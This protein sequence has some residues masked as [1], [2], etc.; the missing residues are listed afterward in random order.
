MYRAHSETQRRG[1]AESRTKWKPFGR[2]EERERERELEVLPI[3]GNWIDVRVTASESLRFLRRIGESLRGITN[4]YR[5]E[6]QSKEPH[7]T[8]NA[9]EFRQLT[10]MWKSGGLVN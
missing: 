2:D 7:I 1:S 5:G 8:T 10:V 3:F 9:G 6:W 4:W